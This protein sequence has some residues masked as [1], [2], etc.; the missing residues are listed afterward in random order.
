MYLVLFLAVVFQ[1]KHFLSDFPLQGKY[2]LRKFSPGWDFIGPLLA[3]VSVH[4]A[5]TFLIVYTILFFTQ[6]LFALKMALIDMCV[7]FTM[8]RLKA[9]PKY[10]GRFKALAAS[11][12]MQASDK[13]KR[14]NNYF[15]WSLGLDQMVHH[16]THYYII[17]RI[18][19]G[20]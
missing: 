16:I 11:E 5:F 4:G 14:W 18:I 10:L 19:S 1:V 15:W 7:H 9:G 3:H 12:Y 2:M 8:D 17:Y 6:P 20:T 13:A